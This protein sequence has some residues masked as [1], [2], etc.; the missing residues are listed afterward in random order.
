MEPVE[1]GNL[2]E[3]QVADLMKAVELSGGPLSNRLAHVDETAVSP[4]S[5]RG[6]IG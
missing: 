1:Y 2:T 3:A 6:G 4:R 5:D